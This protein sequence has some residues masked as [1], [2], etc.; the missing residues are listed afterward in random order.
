M[1]D[2]Y[3]ERAVVWLLSFYR[4]YQFPWS[5][6]RWR[7]FGQHNPGWWPGVRAAHADLSQ[8]LGLLQKRRYFQFS[9]HRPVLRRAKVLHSPLGAI[10]NR[11]FNE[12][13]RPGLSKTWYSSSA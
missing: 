1:R 2:A 10:L 13:Q 7:S 6:S 5:E 8:A 3:R 4:D 11:P 9:S 12:A